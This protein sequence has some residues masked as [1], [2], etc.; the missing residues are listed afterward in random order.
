MILVGLLVNVYHSVFNES[1]LKD[2]PFL[3]DIFIGLQIVHGHVVSQAGMG[4]INK[5]FH[6]M[7]LW[8][9]A[10]YV[11]GKGLNLCRYSPRLSPPFFLVWTRSTTDSSISTRWAYWATNAS[12]NSEKFFIVPYGIL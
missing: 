2:H 10:R 9:G 5:H 12:D 1:L 7:A 11:G 4:I 8:Q 6:Q 3:F